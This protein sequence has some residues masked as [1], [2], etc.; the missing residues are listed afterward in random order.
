MSGGDRLYMYYGGCT[1]H[2]GPYRD[3]E[4]HCNMDPGTLR[5]DGFV[6]ID[7]SPLGGALT[8]APLL[9]SGSELHVNVV[10]NWGHCQV[11]LL[12]ESGEVV[13][14]FSGEECDDIAADT[15]DQVFSWEGGSD[16]SVRAGKATRLRF[17]LQNARL[18]AFPVQ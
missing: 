16:L 17:H 14:G 3:G 10:S 5:A 1:D 13:P 11:E 6:S 18:Y 9:F 15:I 8:I 7:A 4:S 2:H 12:D